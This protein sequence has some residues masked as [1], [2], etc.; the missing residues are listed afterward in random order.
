MKNEI[1]YLLSTIII[2]LLIFSFLIGLAFG[3][4]VMRCEAVKN[5]AAY[6]GSDELGDAKFIWISTNDL[7]TSASSK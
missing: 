4:G 5:G 6:Y 3:K 1:T 7:K 2:V